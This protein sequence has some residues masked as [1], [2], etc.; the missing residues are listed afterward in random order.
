[1]RVK[2]SSDYSICDRPKFLEWENE[3]L[4]VSKVLWEWREP[5]TKH[6]MAEAG[7]RHFKLI[8]FESSGHWKTIEITI[9]SQP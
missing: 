1:M 7:G 6:Y 2:C 4:E 9:P 3:W 5:G 8:F